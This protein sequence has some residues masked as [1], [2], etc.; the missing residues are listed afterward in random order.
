MKTFPLYKIFSNK[1]TQV[2]T[3]SIWLDAFSLDD[4][5]AM[6]KNCFEK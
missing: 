3:K 6:D 4:A 1:Q 5:N 2:E